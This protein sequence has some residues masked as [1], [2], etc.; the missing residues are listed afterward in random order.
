MLSLAVK[1][2]G[3][4]QMLITLRYKNV[5]HFC[6]SCGRIGHA[7][8]N[9][10]ATVEAQGVAYGEELKASPP[11]HT[12]EIMVKPAEIRV[13]QTLF[14]VDNTMRGQLPAD[15]STTRGASSETK[16]RVQADGKAEEGN[17][18][19]GTGKQFVNLVNELHDACNSAKPS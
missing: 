10:D 2:K 15:R 1:V 4:G 14:H 19:G 6:F 13:A 5:P 18:Q 7:A 3:W 12:K 9:Y 11:R 17:S 16:S 8:V